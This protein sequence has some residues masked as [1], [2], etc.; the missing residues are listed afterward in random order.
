MAI[1]NTTCLPL[2]ETQ[3][4]VVRVLTTKK[5]RHRGELNRASQI[6]ALGQQVSSTVMSRPESMLIRQV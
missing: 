2:D 1:L 5:F 4:V 6:Q 3:L